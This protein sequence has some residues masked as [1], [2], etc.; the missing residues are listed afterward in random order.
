MKKLYI[1]SAAALILSAC[2]GT[3]EY[4]TYKATLAAQPAIIDTISSTESY[5]AYIDSL[6]TITSAFEA[7]G[8]KLDETQQ[9]EIETLGIKISEAMNARYQALTS[10]ATDTTRTMLAT[11]SATIV[12]PESVSVTD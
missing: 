12:R 4:D 10:A 3:K 1:A 2:G 11:D 5:G 7:S 9:A 8:V 6:K